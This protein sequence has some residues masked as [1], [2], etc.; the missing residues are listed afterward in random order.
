MHATIPIRRAAVLGA[1]VM[2]SQIAAHLVNCGIPTRLFELSEGGEDRSGPARRAVEKLPRM[3][4]APLLRP[5][6]ARHIEPLNYDDHLAH[7]ADCDLVIEA[8]AERPD[9]KQQ[10]YQRVAPY[11]APGAVI[12][13]NTSGLAIADLAEALP[14]ELRPRFCGIHFFNPPR[15]MHLVEL[16]PHPGSDPRL[17]D[18]VEAFL[19]SSLGKGVIRT[20]DTPNFI[21]NR[22]GVFSMVATMHHAERLGIAPDVVDAL[23]GSAIGRPRSATYRTADLVGLDTLRYVVEGSA[24][25]LGD[26]PWRDYL[27]LPG[28]MAQLIDAGA[29]GEKTKAGVFRKVDG[30]IHVIDPGTGEYRVAEHEAAPEVQEALRQRKPGER[31]QALM[32]LDHPQAEFLWAIHQ[33]L[34]HYA[35]Y[36]LGDIAHNA[37]DADLAVRWGFGWQQGP[38]ETW[39]AAGWSALAEGLQQAIDNGR[40]LAAAPL[41][42][43]VGAVDGVH[44]ADGSYDPTA[45]RR[46]PRSALGAY[47]RQ[48]QPPTVLGEARPE[49]VATFETRAVRLWHRDED[50][51]ILSFRTPA[52]AISA[53]VLDGVIEALEQAQSRYCGVVLW[54]DSDRFSVGADLKQVTEAVQ[55]GRF[56]ELE[57]MVRRFQQATGAVRAAPI[58]V[59]AAIR[60]MALGGGC[61]FVMHTD[62]TVAAQESYL[63]LV[64]AGVG[65]IPAGGGCAELARR[66]AASSPDGDLFPYLRKAFETVAMA[67]VAKGAPEA[68]QLGLLRPSDT[69]IAHADELLHVAHQEARRLGEANY[70]PPLPE[71][72]PVGGRDLLATLEA[73]LVNYHAGGFISDHDYHVAQRSAAALCGGAV[74]GGREVDAGWLLELEVQGFMELLRMEKT[75]ARIQHMLETGKPLR[76]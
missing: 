32:Q 16:T 5:G 15:Y 25:L 21:A 46:T 73:Q 55:G 29:L 10:L 17:C 3:Q 11:L 9:I 56:E 24:E 74:D 23:T 64:E 43:W 39:Q 75:Q 67:T 12:G 45:G 71:P 33:D 44:G 1:G 22:L 41:P 66:A 69:V 48:Y 42:Q 65:L 8:V 57:R 68:Q 50:I 2:G 19:T 51:G 38:F 60:G 36:W 30:R 70:R 72:V 62:H 14:E 4:P 27:R 28:W 54:Q 53:E 13:S 63:G 37:R 20:K 40:T 47:R 52:C 35:A 76:N 49:G 26:D 59:V 18:A 34:F 58:P 31:F 7:L 6:L 61:E